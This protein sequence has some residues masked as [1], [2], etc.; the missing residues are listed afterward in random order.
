M[1]PRFATSLASLPDRELLPR[2]A[3]GLSLLAEHVASNDLREKQRNF[4]PSL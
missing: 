4:H 2:L 1:R 3:E